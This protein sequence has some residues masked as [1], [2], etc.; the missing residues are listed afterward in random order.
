MTKLKDRIA[1]II[2]DGV[3]SGDSSWDEIA[4]EI[5]KQLKYMPE[6]AIPIIIQKYGYMH[7]CYFWADVWEEMIKT[8]QEVE[9]K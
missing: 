5:F 1:K 9:I 3:C 8:A 6:N 2:Q 7:G 4:D